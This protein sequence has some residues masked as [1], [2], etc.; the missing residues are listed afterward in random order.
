[1]QRLLAPLLLAVLV[2]VACT[3]E[4]PPTQDIVDSIPWPDGEELQY[5][6]L[7][8]DG[9]DEVGSGVLYASL[10]GRIWELRLEFEGRE[11]TDESQ[12]TV[13]FETLKPSISRRKIVTPSRDEEATGEYDT[14]ENVVTITQ[15]VDG[16]T[17]SSPRR[18]EEHYY[19]N[20]SSLYLWRTIPFAEGYKASYHSVLVNRGNQPVVTLEVVGREEVTV[21]AGAFDAWKLEIRWESRKQT[22]WFADDNARTLV[23]Y[24]NTDTVFELLELPTEEV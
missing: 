2:A 14:E 18:L 5:R 4:P 23:K 10:S 15:T 3:A 21:P 8:S 16:E 13:D 19:D 12:V 7:E 24:D 11:S 17:S 1:M 20:E 6:L 22:A 9:G